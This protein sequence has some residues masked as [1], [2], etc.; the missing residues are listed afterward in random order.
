MNIKQIKKQIVKWED[1]SF[2]EN[3][4]I[5]LCRYVNY[6]DEIISKRYRKIIQGLTPDI[7]MKVL[8]TLQNKKLFDDNMN[9]IGNTN[10][11]K[12]DRNE[13]IANGAC[14]R[15]KI[16][17]NPNSAKQFY[18][19]YMDFANGKMSGIRNFDYSKPLSELKD[20][21]SIEI[22]YW[23]YF[24][25]K[26]YQ[27]FLIST[28]LHENVH[29]WTIV[30]TMMDEPI[31]VFAMEGFVEKEARNIADEN[32]LE[33]AKCFRPDETML[34]DYLSDGILN[35]HDNVVLMLYCKNAMLCLIN[36]M[37]IKVFE[38]IEEKSPE[39]ARKL[40]KKMYIELMH[41]IK[42]DITSNFGKNYREIFAEM[43]P[44][45]SYDIINFIETKIARES[46]TLK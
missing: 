29:R 2:L 30:S 38:E 37:M 40:A 26:T 34:I 19:S 11:V 44:N 18:A 12:F 24:N 39:K 15:G 35:E 1:E 14:K 28:M 22:L 31:D 5:E 41:N 43:K 23:Y 13:Q 3:I 45:K 25:E 17:V 32:N 33:Y 21:S 27:D 16:I 8:E 10:I 9:Y 36:V 6:L 46:F 4:R 20:L 42:I 7:K